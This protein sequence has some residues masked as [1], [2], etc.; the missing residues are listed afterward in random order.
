MKKIIAALT[1]ALAVSLTGCATT[2]TAATDG[3]ITVIV[4]FQSLD[5][6]NKTAQCLEA[7]AGANASDLVKQAGFTLEGTDKYGL[8]IVCRV[9]GLPSATQI[10]GNHKDYRETCADMP[11]EFAYW[12]I[13]VRTPEKDW[14]FAE[15]G[16]ADLKLNPGEQLAL[17]FSVDGAMALPN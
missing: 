4:D 17:L 10:I 14:H 11:A 13:L 3:C 9:N 5:N 7:E 15:V 8:M 1:L 16:I 2:N 6:G 12:S